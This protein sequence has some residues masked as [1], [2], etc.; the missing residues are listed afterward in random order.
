MIYLYGAGGHAKVIA[1]IFEVNGQN[2][3]GVFDDDLSK[4]LFDLSAL[5]FPGPVDFLNDQLLIS[6]GNNTIRKK[7]ASVIEASYVSAI[8]PS[9]YISKT[10]VIKEGTAVMAGVVINADTIIGKHCIINTSASVDHD[11]VISDFAHISPHAALCGGITVGEGAQIG[12]GA[13]ITP[14]KKI[15]VNTIIG[16][17]AVVIR[18]VPDSVVVVG[19]PARIIRQIDIR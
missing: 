16:A 1:E 7:I 9:A 15:G 11:C 8:H 17:G 4:K 6:V 12:T 13:I 3:T 10:A 14:G 5:T 19:N 2:N 18:D